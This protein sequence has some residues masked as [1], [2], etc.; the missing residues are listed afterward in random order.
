[1]SQIYSIKNLLNIKDINITFTEIWKY[2]SRKI[3][4]KKY[5]TLSELEKDI[6]EYIKFYNEE[7]F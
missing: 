5:T 6:S 3:L 4:F 2:K 1:M 7:R